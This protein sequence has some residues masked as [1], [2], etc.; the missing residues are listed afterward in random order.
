VATPTD[1][2]LTDT[3]AVKITARDLIV[4][5]PESRPS[6]DKSSRRALAHLYVMPLG[7]RVGSER[8]VLNVEGDYPDGVWVCDKL[9]LHAR[10]NSSLLLVNKT[11]SYNNLLPSRPV[12]KATPSVPVRP[13]PAY[14]AAPQL[15]LLDEINNLRWQ[16]ARLCAKVGLPPD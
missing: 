2:E 16:I 14:E 6:K 4:D 15:N 5:C 9:V 3:N 10:P 13:V 1:I 12:N 7:S 11:G 8:L